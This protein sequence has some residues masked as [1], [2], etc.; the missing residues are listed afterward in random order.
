VS[1]D[2]ARPFSPKHRRY[3]IPVTGGMLLIG[4]INI[5]IGYCSYVPPGEPP[6]RILPVLPPPT[7]AAR[8]TDGTIGLAEVPAVVMR[9]F[10]VKYPRHVATPKKLD[11]T[12]YEMSFT[13]GATARHV[14]Y[15]EDGTF[16]GER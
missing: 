15:R 9:A 12:T 6:A 11:A 3:W 7:P 14:T 13:D 8:A 16:V 4:V 10:A 2:R 5:G 1:K